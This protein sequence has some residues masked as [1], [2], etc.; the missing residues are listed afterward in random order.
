MQ[1]VLAASL[2]LTPAL[3]A[4]IEINEDPQ[5]QPALDWLAAVEAADPEMAIAAAERMVDLPAVASSEKEYADMATSEG[6]SPA[7][8]AEPFNKFDF[9]LWYDAW[10]MQKLLHEFGVNEQT[11]NISKLKLIFD[12]VAERIAP[13][14]K[15]IALIPWPAGVWVRQFG[16]CDRQSWLFA[17]LAYQAGFQTQI[18]YLVNP[19]T[20][21]SPHTICEVLYDTADGQVKHLVACV[22]SKIFLKGKSVAE[23]A[24]D[25]EMIKEIWPDRPEWWKSLPKSIFWTPSFPQDYCR[26]NQLLHSKLL[27]AIGDKCPAFA[28]DPRT[29][30]NRYFKTSGRDDT[31]EKGLWYYPFRLLKKELELIQNKN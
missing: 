29:R 31:F 22:F 13:T 3:D 28:E 7:F 11:D 17:E 23:L 20:G 9:K 14:E 2:I 12:K 8:L 25:P 19:D 30:M 27:D 24:S 6:I 26:K 5:K 21:E 1:Y 18:V 4:A 15:D 16:L 10:F